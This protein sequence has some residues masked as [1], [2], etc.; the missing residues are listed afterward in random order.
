MSPRRSSRARITQPP[1]A[2]VKDPR[3]S[4]SSSSSGRAER[5]NRLNQKVS[6]PRKSSA[7]SPEENDNDVVHNE[8]GPSRR[9]RHEHDSDNEGDPDQNTN[10][11]ENA[12]PEEEEDDEDEE[13]VTR[14][15]CRQTDYPGL[16]GDKPLG[17]RRPSS[18]K[19]ENSS[20]V[21]KSGDG[22]Q[23][24]PG[25]FIQCD[26]CKVWQHGGCVGILDESMSPEEYYCEECRKDLHSLYTRPD[27]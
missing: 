17:T 6:S 25:L 9:R 12:I 4:A 24:D 3:S 27:G 11:E 13:E 16:P 18:V 7:L 8:S 19:L 22:S 10:L 14:C 1:S 20:E 26:T 23:D 15:V 21:V 2:H 5:T